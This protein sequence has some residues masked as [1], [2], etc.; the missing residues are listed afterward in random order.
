MIGATQTPEKKLEM[1]N[2]NNGT[3]IYI[4]NGKPIE[5]IDYYENLIHIINLTEFNV[6][7][8]SLRE[9][10]DQLPKEPPAYLTKLAEKIENELILFNL[11][12][13]GIKFI[14]GNM[15]DE[16]AEKIMKKINEI[17]NNEDNLTSF[18]NKLN[19]ITNTINNNLQEISSNANDLN[20][21]L[22]KLSGNYSKAIAKLQLT[23]RKKIV[24]DEIYNNLQHLY[25]HILDVKEAITFTKLGR[26][27]AHLLDPAELDNISM[28]QYENIKTGLLHNSDTELLYFVIQKPIISTEKC[29]QTIITAVPNYTN[30]TE[31]IFDDTKKYLNCNS[32]LFTY[33]T[34]EIRNLQPVRNNCL[35][36]LFAYEEAKCQYKRNTDQKIIQIRENVIMTINIGKTF[37]I[38]D[39]N[40]ET[41]TYLEG[42]YLIRFN[43]CSIKIQNQ[44]YTSRFTEK[45]DHFM[46]PEMFAKVTADIQPIITLND[47]HLKN[48][49]QQE[50]IQIIHRQILHTKQYLLITA[51]IITTIITAAIIIIRRRTRRQEPTFMG[52]GVTGRDPYKQPHQTSQSTRNG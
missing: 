19:K 28:I 39:C 8:N 18:S 16:D 40:N 9:N 21:K 1:F 31:I 23:L 2:M 15:D 44:M 5:M 29:Y 20:G 32:K 4:I 37:I 22:S 46:V 35:E 34:N 45:F 33:T 43:N 52:G 27:S 3:D 11:L 17:E 26:L 38:N 51:I 25:N 48:I 42:T 7:L 30:Q 14:T 36:K 47:I 50:D 41:P 24:S 12:G 13:R 6:A 10:I 49:E